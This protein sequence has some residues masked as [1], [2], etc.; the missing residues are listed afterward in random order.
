MNIQK[1]ISLNLYTTFKTGGIAE[2]FC[3]IKTRE[4]LLECFKWIKEE[5]LEY[6][7]LGNGSNLLVNDRGFSGVVVKMNNTA[8]EWN[9]D[10]STT[11]AGIMLAN[12][13][14]EAKKRSLGG[15]ERCFGIPATL[16][17]AVRNSAGAYGTQLSSFIES[18]EIFDTEKGEFL[19]ISNKDCGFSYHQSVFQERPNWLIWQIQMKWQEK[20]AGAIESETE[21]YLDLR[22]QN[23]P[24]E[25]P[26]A[27]SF[28][29]NPSIAFLEKSKKNNLIDLFVKNEMKR[30]PKEDKESQEKEIRE[31]CSQSE[32]L[33]AAFLIDATGLK[34]RSVGGAQ[35]SEKHANFIVNTGNAKT[36]DVI[37]LG[38]VVKQKVRSK[39]SV[40]LFEEVEYVGF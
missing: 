40:Q 37:I 30:F 18:V 2:Y 10:V 19:N 28:F 34:G 4:E 23:Q 36:E 31:K 11:G 13:I 14:L 33:P 27:G 26:S 24:L 16:G 3:E 39:F 25:K 35:V 12:L 21:K 5:K 7:F 22:K 38:S 32:S 9:E 20:D 15:L 29:R 17:G 8:V 6:F 1:N